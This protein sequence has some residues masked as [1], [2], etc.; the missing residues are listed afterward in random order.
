MT[1][2]VSYLRNGTLPEDRNASYRLKVWFSRF[3]MMGDV[4]YKKDFSCLYLRCLIPNEAD[5]IIREVHEGIC[6][7]HS[8]ARLL[9]HKLIRAGYY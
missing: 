9:V 2:I 3:V 8:G 4:L 5:Y 1:L 6:G 7:N